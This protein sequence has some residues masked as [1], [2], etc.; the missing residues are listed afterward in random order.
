LT[1]RTTSAIIKIQN[2]KPLNDPKEKEIG[3]MTKKMTKKDYFNELKNIP[4]VAEN[5]ALMNFID[6]EIDLLNRKN[7]SSTGEKKMTATQK[8][9]EELKVVILEVL[10][11]HKE[12]MTITEM[13]KADARLGELTNQKISAVIRLMLKEETVDRIEDKKKAMF[14]PM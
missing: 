2:N 8:A 12:P 9:N 1:D 11:A 5:E 10:K 4:A 13:M 6:H 7:T 3:T 14:K